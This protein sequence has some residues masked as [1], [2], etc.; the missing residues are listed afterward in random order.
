[1]S[2]PTGFQTPA[3]PDPIEEDETKDDEVEVDGDGGDGGD[4]EPPTTTATSTN[5]GG[6]PRRPPPQGVDL[7][8]DAKMRFDQQNTQGEDELPLRPEVRR[9]GIDSLLWPTKGQITDKLEEA[10]YYVPKHE[11]GH[12]VRQPSY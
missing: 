5:P 8:Q 2:R 4:Q 10:T 11:G 6:P 7:G 1:M 12:H 3:A 9:A